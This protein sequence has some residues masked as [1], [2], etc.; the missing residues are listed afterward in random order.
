MPT[1]S[2][3]LDDEEV[4]GLIA[5]G[6][7][8]ALSRLIDRY[9][10]GLTVFTTRFLQNAADADDVV[11]EVFL[12]AWDKAHK[13]N[14]KRG[15]LSTWLYRIA[16]NKCIDHQRRQR[17]RSWVGLDDKQSTI[18]DNRPSPFRKIEANQEVR[19]VQ[20]AIAKLPQRQRMALLMS[21]IDDLSS[22]DI[23][24]VM[25]ANA[26]TVNQLI[27]RARKSIRMYISKMDKTKERN[28]EP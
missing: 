13:Y 3:E 4:M 5:D 24:V 19:V 2:I 28:D 7:Q 15:R 27:S 9:G 22:T 10:H 18:A 21:V 12:Q 25:G 23:A 11:Q 6:D 20:Q 17:F 8:A 16:V 1:P 26:N 14:R